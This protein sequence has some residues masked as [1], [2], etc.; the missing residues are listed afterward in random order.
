MASGSMVRPATLYFENDYWNKDKVLTAALPFTQSII[1]RLGEE[2]LQH[3]ISCGCF[4]VHLYQRL[5]RN[6]GIE[7]AVE[8]V[9]VYNILTYFNFFNTGHK[10]ADCMLKDESN[11]AKKLLRESSFQ[12]LHRWLDSFHALFGIDASLPLPTTCCWCLAEP[13]EEWVHNQMFVLLELG[14]GMD[15]SSD[16]MRSA[17]TGEDSGQVGATFYGPLAEHLTSAPLW[18]S[19]D[20]KKVTLVC[21]GRCYNMAWGRSGGPPPGSRAARLAARNR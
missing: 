5:L 19:V 9:C 20:G 11:A 13:H 12:Q 7:L 1:N 15:I 10:D 14:V 21:P 8:D 16:I 2:A 18:T 4:L 17:G 3:Q 6:R